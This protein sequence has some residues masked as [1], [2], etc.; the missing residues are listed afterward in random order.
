[1]HFGFQAHAAHADGLAHFLVVDDEFLRLHQQQPLVGGDV[2][3][4]GGLDHA[5]DIRLRD[6]AVFDGHHAGR[7]DAADMAAGDT[8]VDAGDLAVRHQLGFFER[9]L[10]AGNGRVDVHDHAAL[11]AEARRDAVACQFQFAVGQYLCDHR[12]HFGSADVQANDQIFVFFC[13][14]FYLRAVISV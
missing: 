14:R 8:G 7:V 13:H 9:L 6:L 12:H 3:R 1:M 5:R 4:F 11:E 10:D 2:D